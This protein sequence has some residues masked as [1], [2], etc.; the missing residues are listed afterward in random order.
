MCIRDRKW[1]VNMSEPDL[2]KIEVLK[3]EVEGFEV[4]EDVEKYKSSMLFI[5]LDT[6]VEMRGEVMG[7]RRTFYSFAQVVKALTTPNMRFVPYRN[8]KLTRI[9]K[10]SLGGNAK[11]LVVATIEKSIDRY[12][13][14][15]QTLRLADRLKKIINRPVMNKI[16]I[17]SETL[18][19]NLEYEIQKIKM[20]LGDISI[21]PL[22]FEESKEKPE[23]KPVNAENAKKRI[24]KLEEQIIILKENAVKGK[25][26]K[27]LQIDMDIKETNSEDATDTCH[28]ISGATINNSLHK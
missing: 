12:N 20:E 15:L 19:L 5:D 23:A 22:T 16:A 9:L 4:G 7:V 26:H 3:V 2:R 27:K 13:D 24:E 1:A 21:D 8:S 25:K 10:D 18:I 11:T 14:K 28:N 17:G 6:P